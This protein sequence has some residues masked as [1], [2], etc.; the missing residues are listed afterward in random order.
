MMTPIAIIGAECNLP[1]AANTEAFWEMI[2]QG[3]SALGKVPECRLNRKLFYDP[4]GGR[5]KTSTDLGGVIDYSLVDPSRCPLPE[6]V[7]KS[8]DRLQL[9]LAV[10]VADACRNAGYEP[11]HFPVRNAGVFLGTTRSGDRNLELGIRAAFPEL[12]GWLNQLNS[13]QESLAPEMRLEVLEEVRK[14]ADEKLARIHEGVR[15]RFSSSDT[16]ALIAQ[17][18]R[19]DGPQIVFNAACA[20]SLHAL[21]QAIMNLQLGRIDLA[22][23]G[24]ASYFHSDILILFASSGAMTANRACPM[25]RDADGMVIGEGNAVFL[26]KR[27]EDAIAA[28]DSIQAVFTGMGIA[29][30]GKGKSLWAPR[31][32]G[33]VEA[34]ERAYADGISASDVDYIEG[35]ATSTALGD[36]TEV[37]AVSMAFGNALKDR[38]IPIGSAKG[39][40]GHTL[41]AAGAVGVLKTLLMMKHK[42]FPPVAGLRTPNPKIH[43]DSV[44]V[45]A[46]R[47]CHPW[48]APKGNRPRRAGVNAFGIG[49][50]NVHLV[51][52]EYLP[53]YWNA[54]LEKKKNWPEVK[55]DER[56]AVVGC[57][58]I[59]PDAYNFKALEKLIFTEAN[60]I[61]TMPLNRWDFTRILAN[62][63]PVSGFAGKQPECGSIDQYQYDWRKNRI[64]PKQIANA[65]PLQFMMLDAVNEALNDMNFD[66]S[67]ESRKRTGVVVGTSFGGHFADQMNLILWMPK[68]QDYLRHEFEA[69]GLSEAKIAK[70]LLELADFMHKKMPVLMD[71]TGSFTPS[72]FSS[73]ITKALDLHGGAVT[74]EAND[75]SSGAALMCC[76]DQLLTGINDT[77]IC[78]SGQFGL[79]PGVII[80]MVE[81]GTLALDGRISPF[82]Q[83]SNG[84]V[85]GEGCGAVILKRYADAKK[86]GDQ[87]LAV[88]SGIGIGGGRA[89][90]E[91][92]HLALRR[93][94]IQKLPFPQFLETDFHGE[95]VTEAKIIHSLHEAREQ[96]HCRRP[97]RIGTR[98]NQTGY[99]CHGAGMVSLITAIA[100]M[101]NKKWAASPQLKEPVH[102]FLRYSDVLLPAENVDIPDEAVMGVGFG[103]SAYCYANLQKSY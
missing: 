12:C 86:H 17:M 100:E 55:L 11:E 3:R 46:Y 82:D 15:P 69:R 92:V 61:R 39:N 41:E 93:A 102:C 84:C 73:R 22:I 51:M 48:E 32:E 64:P 23:A 7:L 19:L 2:R 4:K 54:W 62:M 89:I 14:K 40:V 81:Q 66:R 79:S 47:E 25:D 26:L 59:Y 8:F 77:M 90:R 63:D 88:I 30:D 103:E 29:S 60:G 80:S 96:T 70:I 95:T 21:S 67:L 87:I 16:A 36:V 9:A 65:N 45:V 91:N 6:S 27:L 72:A 53:E 98:T 58:C 52:D 49:G 5:N 28:G 97:V 24:G 83:N 38:K 20:S 76:L 101:K 33:Q 42:M 44:P 75:I 43:W 10:T 57:G 71:E 13:F 1:G 74:V 85:L 18:L 94:G 35:H 34:L 56:I 37:E 50:L 99:L 68:F 31:K 78:L